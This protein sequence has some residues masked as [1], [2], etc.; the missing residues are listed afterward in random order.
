MNGPLH[1]WLIPLLPFAGFLLNGILG[2][3][4]AQVAGDDDCAAGAAG[5]IWRG[6][7]MPRL[8][9]SAPAL[10]A[11]LRR[12]LS[13]RLDQRRP[14][15]VDFSFVLDQLSLVM[16]LV[17]TGVGFLI[18]I[19]SVGYMHDDEGYCALLQLPEPLPLLHD[20]AGAGRQRAADVCRLGGRGPRVVP[21]HRLLVQKKTRRRTRARRHSSSTASATSDF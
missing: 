11:A 6:V 16:L 15:H 20:G 7:R 17:V 9:M 8:R 1:L 21:A 14:L 13:D 18:H 5:G 3:T 10:G 12:D 4:P 2:R 19:Y